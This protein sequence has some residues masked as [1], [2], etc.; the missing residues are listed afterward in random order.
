[1][2]NVV[3]LKAGLPKFRMSAL[4]IELVAEGKMLCVTLPKSIDDPFWI[5]PA[6]GELDRCVVNPARV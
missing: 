5:G 2:E 4:I 6:G 1:M 3:D